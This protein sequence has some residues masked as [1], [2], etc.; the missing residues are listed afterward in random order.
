MSADRNH[1]G[2]EP[3][4]STA[5][6][7][8]PFIE[9]SKLRAVVPV[10]PGM[11]WKNRCRR[12]IASSDWDERFLRGEKWLNRVCLVLI[13]SSVFYFGPLLLFRLLK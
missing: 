1:K 8:A 5:M 12:F 3:M 11:D 10:S 2:E 9:Q 7:S 13:L 6:T 4:H